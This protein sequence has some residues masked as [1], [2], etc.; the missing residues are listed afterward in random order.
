MRKI[1]Q[2]GSIMTSARRLS[3]WAALAGAA[4][5][6]APAYAQNAQSPP[7]S[8]SQT[9]G[10]WT[11][12]CYRVQGLP[13][14]VMQAT[15]DRAHRILV[16]SVSIAY[17]PKNG[18]YFGRFVLPLGVAFDQGM[19]LE[20][21][22]FRADNLKFRICERDGCYVTGLLPQALIDAMEAQGTAKGQISATFVD[23]RKIQ[24]PI[25]LDGFSDGLNALKKKTNE[26]EAAA[27]PKK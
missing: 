22:A 6:C 14:D 10:N 18:A 25:V 27:A 15:V 3:L 4:L 13:C 26:T 8:F 12:R 16:A 5:L 21:G 7:V 11:V 17:V 9:Y 2:T 23:G 20:I 19:G 1:L 24:I